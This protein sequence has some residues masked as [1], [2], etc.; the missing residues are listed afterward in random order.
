[1]QTHVLFDL[2]IYLSRMYDETKELSMRGHDLAAVLSF[3]SALW[4]HNIISEHFTHEWLLYP[5][6]AF[7]FMSSL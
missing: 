1:M 6:V 3:D 7:V 5:L 2:E 4:G